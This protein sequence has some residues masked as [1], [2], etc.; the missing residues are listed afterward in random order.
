MPSYFLGAIWWL[1]CC[2]PVNIDFG[3]PVAVVSSAETSTNDVSADV[4]E[5]FSILQSYSVGNISRRDIQNVFDVSFGEILQGL[6]TLNLRLPIAK[7]PAN[8]TIAQEKFADDYFKGDSH[9]P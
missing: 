7:P 4:R 3:K 1:T 5:F 8:R 6:A 2:W 9:K